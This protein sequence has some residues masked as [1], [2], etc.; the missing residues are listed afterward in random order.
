MARSAKD[1]SSA[2]LGACISDIFTTNDGC[3]YICISVATDKSALVRKLYKE[4]GEDDA[5]FI[6]I[7]TEELL[8][9]SEKRQWAITRWESR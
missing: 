8:A 6:K 3:D 2:T 4:D 9:L 5:H 1:L 7:A